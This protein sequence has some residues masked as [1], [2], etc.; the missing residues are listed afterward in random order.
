MNF[1]MAPGAKKVSRHFP[2]EFIEREM[3]KCRCTK[4]GAKLLAS[5]GVVSAVREKYPDC[6]IV[7]EQCM[8]WT[9]PDP[10]LLYFPAPPAGMDQAAQNPDL[11]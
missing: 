11:N 6:E 9:F 5:K 3:Q 10:T 4:C 8:D 1:Y 7:C 2:L